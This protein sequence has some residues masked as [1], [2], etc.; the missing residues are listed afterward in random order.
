MLNENGCIFIQI[1]LKYI[2]RSLIDIRSGDGLVLERWQAFT[3]TNDD[4]FFN[5]IRYGVTQPQ[6][7]DLIVS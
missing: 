5:A 6:C 7:K 3:W 4:I 2:P 1:W